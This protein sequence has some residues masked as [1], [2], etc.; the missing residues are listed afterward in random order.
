MI[1][2]GLGGNMPSER[3]GPPRATLEAALS[4]LKGHGVQICR[5]SRWYRSQPLPDDGQPWYVNGVSEIATILPPGGLLALLLEIERKFGRERRTRW[6]P[7]TIDLDLLAYHDFSNWDCRAP[8][9][10]VLPHPRLHE[11]SFVLAPLAELA[12]GWRHPVLGRTVEAM[13]EALPTGQYVAPLEPI[14]ESDEPG[15]VAG[16]APA[17]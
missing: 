15:P 11:R 6:A 16:G 17:R 13:L 3:F 12:P 4:A 1:F 7:R 8:A 14:P 10:P 9:D 5:R 2:L